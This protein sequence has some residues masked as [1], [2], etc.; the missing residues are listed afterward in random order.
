[1]LNIL[2]D[3]LNSHINTYAK[4]NEEFLN[5]IY[6]AYEIISKALKNNNKLLIFGNGGSAA[7]A[8]HFAAELSGRYKVER[9]GLSAIALST[10]TS[11]LTAIANDY[12]YEFVFSRQVQAI[13]KKGD[14]LFGI[15][16]SGS[17]KNV[18]EAFKEGEKLACVNIMLSSNKAT[19][20]KYFNIKAPSLDTPRIQ[21]VHIFVIHSICHLL[22][23][24]FK[25]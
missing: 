18:L 22:D 25:V 10:D 23:L 9:K 20:D 21:E 4:I 6:K 7:D 13:A 3:E 24:E 2:K 8:Q 15:S 16:T 11:A 12:G 14:I 17:S 5:D 1:M 19:N